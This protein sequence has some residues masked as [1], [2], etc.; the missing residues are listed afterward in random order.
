MVQC[1]GLRKVPSSSRGGAVKEGGARRSELCAMR[2]TAC[3]ATLS[4]LRASVS[5]VASPSSRRVSG[6][7]QIVACIALLSMV[8]S[9]CGGG[10]GSTA[11]NAGGGADSLSASSASSQA[12][13]TGIVGGTLAR[14]GLPVNVQTDA[15][16]V[17]GSTTTMQG[18]Y[19]RV[20]A[21][22]SSGPVVVVL[23]RDANTHY[24]TRL[25][26]LAAGDT[27]VTI[28]AATTIA[29][30][31]ARLAPRASQAA[32]D[33]QVGAYL[34]LPS[35]APLATVAAN[36]AY[37]FDER[38]FLAAAAQHGSFDG[39]VALNAQ[40]ANKRAL[41]R[42]ASADAP[43]PALYPSPLSAAES[44][45]SLSSVGTGLLSG[46]GASLK[47]YAGQAV[48]GWL[49]AE[50][51]LPTRT[52]AQLNRIES[53]LSDIKSEL[54][55]IKAE[56]DSLLTALQNTLTTL[57]SAHLSDTLTYIDTTTLEVKNRAAL[58]S[59]DVLNVSDQENSDLANDILTHTTM[60][61]DIGQAQLGYA[62]GTGFI[63]LT[64]PRYGDGGRFINTDTLQ[65]W[66]KEL[67]YYQSYQLRAVNLL[68]QACFLK[69][70]A[71]RLSDAELYL[72]QFHVSAKQQQMLIPQQ[73]VFPGLLLFLPSA[74]N[75]EPDDSV[76]IDR[77]TGLMWKRDL[78]GPCT[79]ADAGNII[80]QGYNAPIDGYYGWRLPT[81]AE[82]QTLGATQDHLTNAVGIRGLGAWWQYVWT[83]DSFDDWAGA[84]AETVGQYVLNLRDA[85]VQKAPLHTSA[86]YGNTDYN[87][88]YQLLLVRTIVTPKVLPITITS[89]NVTGGV[90]LTAVR[91]YGTKGNFLGLP[92]YEEDI[93]QRVIWSVTV[94]NDPTS[95]KV[96]IG[97]GPDSSGLLQVRN[98]LQ[99][100]DVVTV[101]A[102]L[103]DQSQSLTLS[104]LPATDATVASLVISPARTLVLAQ[105]QPP[106]NL[107]ATAVTN[108]G[109]PSNVSNQVT[110]S[111]DTPGLV[112]ISP[113]GAVT[114]VGPLPNVTTN[115]KITATYQGATATAYIILP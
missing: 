4:R 14:E 20:A 78:L 73:T 60:V 91:S 8:L 29:A 87:P 72:D 26:R 54:D 90:R 49:M 32:T 100:G 30:S 27:W 99:P 6:G 61:P 57:L 94:N 67:T 109:V 37:G 38:T 39:F 59:S 50:I 103:G 105:G 71:A 92:Y 12:T 3:V 10:G 108:S 81:V 65:A 36:R 47:S 68:L 44:G 95:T 16:K 96:H 25:D 15:G 75:T 45:F 5:L 77:N 2:I 79:W 80:V 46:L 58:S 64:V 9:G 101:T 11:S 107:T 56:L 53:L 106:I 83:S 70:T 104:N 21:P 63:S 74:A 102:Q 42:Q 84:Y 28:N 13:V 69:A 24:A 97:N 22:S 23:T 114:L 82:L 48:I 115:V 55:D 40:T 89:A 86:T 43:G 62:T 111:S 35:G 66:Q 93:T 31:A 85:D 110:W 41:S 76:V 112:T 51:G 19:F 7:L 17:L 34:G 33:E 1:H 18:G 52:E 88:T 98:N 113:L